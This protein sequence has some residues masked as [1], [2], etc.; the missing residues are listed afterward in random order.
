MSNVVP[1]RRGAEGKPDLA[2]GRGG[3]AVVALASSATA[4]GRTMLVANLAAQAGMAGDG[5]VA[6]LDADPGGSLWRWWTRRRGKGGEPSFADRLGME[7]VGESLAG[8]E[9]QG[10][11]LCFIDT[12]PGNAGTLA[13]V[14]EAANM[15]VIPA[16]A[17]PAGAEEASVLGRSLIGKATIAFVLN[18][19]SHAGEQQGNMASRLAAGGGWSAGMVR[20]ADAFAISMTAGRTVIETHPDI[21]AASDIAELWTNLRGILVAG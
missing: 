20:H 17:D 3:M 1:F 12:P 2:S 18:G 6:V 13:P 15:V 10:A 21:Y 7:A 5:P 9:E 11:R 4:T 8:L 19:R 16:D 14:A